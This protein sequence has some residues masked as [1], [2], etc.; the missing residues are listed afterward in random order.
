MGTKCLTEGTEAFI[1]YDIAKGNSMQVKVKVKARKSWNM[2]ERALVRHAISY[3]ITRL[4][5]WSCPVG[6]EV[7]L[8]NFNDEDHYGDSIDLD[9][10]FVVRITKKDNWVKT[11]FHEL[12]HVRQYAEDELELEVGTAMWR[13][14]RFDNPDYATCPWEVMACAVEESLY[15]EFEE[16]MI[17]FFS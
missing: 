16:S 1:I 8:K 10:R 7:I 12:E 17:H 4:G 9:D 13:G 15:E 14:E 11:I 2:D 5:L 6:L 3:G